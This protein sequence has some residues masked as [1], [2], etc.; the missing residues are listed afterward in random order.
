MR[1][2]FGAVFY[3]FTIGRM[4]G[5]LWQNK[6]S[7]ESG[8]RPRGDWRMKQLRAWA[9]RLMGLFTQT[10]RARELAD[11]L[12]SHLQMHIDDNLRAGM[13]PEHARR[14]AL[15][16]LGGVQPTMQAYRD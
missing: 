15:L 13:T 16:K 10:R 5:F 14:H 11:E 4:L 2:A 8:T 7:G 3:C 6:R 12:D 9:M 1:R